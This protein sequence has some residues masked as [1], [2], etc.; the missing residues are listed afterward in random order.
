FATFASSPNTYLVHQAAYTKAID[1]VAW[2]RP[3][4]SGNVLVAAGGARFDVVLPNEVHMVMWAD[5]GTP[6][7]FSE[8]VVAAEPGNS[9]TVAA[10]APLQLATLVAWIERIDSSSTYSVKGKLVSCTKSG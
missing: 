6:L 2:N 8:V 5:D 4:L 3:I 1:I 10:A 7:G 9:I